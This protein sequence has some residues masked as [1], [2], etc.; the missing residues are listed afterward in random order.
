M[1]VFYVVAVAI[2]IG[3]LSV[4]GSLI[5]MDVQNDGIFHHTGSYVTEN[6]ALNDHTVAFDGID[7]S[8]YIDTSN[9][10]SIFSATGDLIFIDRSYQ[11]EIPDDLLSIAGC[12]FGE[13]KP[14]K[15]NEIDLSGV[16]SGTITTANNQNRFE[17]TSTGDGVLSSRLVYD[18]ST[19]SL[20]SVGKMNLTYSIRKV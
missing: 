8:Q 17:Y 19:D 13:S 18:N 14:P 2:I 10:D 16:I 9:L 4:S 1:K 20:R 15:Q 11:E 5:S 3:S 12:V 6:G 7:L